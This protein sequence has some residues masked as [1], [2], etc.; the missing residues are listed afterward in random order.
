[1][2]FAKI[3]KFFNQIAKKNANSIVGGNAKEL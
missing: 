2:H 1:M 3:E